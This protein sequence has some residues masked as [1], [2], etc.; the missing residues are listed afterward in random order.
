MLTVRPVSRLKRLRA[1]ILAAVV[2]A[3]TSILGTNSAIAFNF[4][5]FYPEMPLSDALENATNIGG[6]PRPSEFPGMFTFIGGRG[7][8]YLI[9]FCDN[10]LES[11][12]FSRIVSSSERGEVIDQNDQY[13]GSH[14][15]VSRTDTG[16]IILWAGDGYKEILNYV[17]NRIDSVETQ[18]V[19]FREFLRHYPTRNCH[20]SFFD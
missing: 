8:A 9:K 16:M 4:R 17:K 15:V 10:K 1:T 6:Y 19:V 14:K 13:Y 5:G 7:R 18:I 12:N 2:V 11:M 3:T 20:E